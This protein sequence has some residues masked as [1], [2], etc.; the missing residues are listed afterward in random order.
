MNK[1]WNKDGLTQIVQTY[2]RKQ[3]DGV[4]VAGSFD[5]AINLLT[6]TPL[7]DKVDKLFVIGG[8]SVYKVSCE[9]TLTTVMFHCSREL[10]PYRPIFIKW[11]NHSRANN[12][13]DNAWWKVP[14]CTSPDE[15]EDMGMFARLLVLEQ[16]CL[17]KQPP[18]NNNSH[19]KQNIWG[20]KYSVGHCRRQL[21]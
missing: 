18:W 12:K 14:N 11:L 17:G 19:D 6:S 2:F 1:L 15:Q 21:G 9:S 20:A 3:P 10:L 16:M 13:L 7:V 5:E 4:Y 8:S